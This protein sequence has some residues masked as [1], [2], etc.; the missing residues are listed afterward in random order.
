MAEPR[1]APTLVS[2]RARGDEILRIAA[3]HG[4]HNVHVCGSIA[5]GAPVSGSDVDPPVDMSPDARGFAYF[6]RLHGLRGRHRPPSSELKSR[7]PT[8]P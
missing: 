5:R 2:L 8:I 4:A 6:G 7:H 1:L 3:S